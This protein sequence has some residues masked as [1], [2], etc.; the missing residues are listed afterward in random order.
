MSSNSTLA[1]IY[2]RDAKAYNF[3][4]IPVA[5]NIDRIVSDAL[6]GIEVELEQHQ[7]VRK[8]HL[9]WEYKEDGSLR[10]NG[11]EYVSRI[12]RAVDAPDLLDNLFNH[13]LTDDCAFSLRTSIHVHLNVLDLTV[14]QMQA[15]VLL[16]SVFEDVFYKYAGRGRWKNIYCVPI[17]QTGVLSNFIEKTYKTPWHK[18]TGLNL[19]RMSE[20]GTIEF[21]HLAGTNS[22]NRIVNWIG[23]ICKFREFILKNDPKVLLERLSQLDETSDYF[24]LLQE[25]VGEYMSVIKFEDPA[26]YIQAAMKI[27]T[28]FLKSSYTVHYARAMAVESKLYKVYRSLGLQERY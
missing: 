23:L 17:T 22:V 19:K 3:K 20:I 13:A 27:K 10:N 24:G 5:D 16:Y 1:E 21:R 8:P 12:M 11:A 25:V 14:Q 15:F 9:M 7:T 26:N 28:A 2:D 4:P 18:Y 6:I